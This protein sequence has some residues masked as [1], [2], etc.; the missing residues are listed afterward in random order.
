MG[1]SCDRSRA[2]ETPDHFN[3]FRCDREDF[4]CEGWEVSAAGDHEDDLF[5][6]SSGSSKWRCKHFQVGSLVISPEL[7]LKA[8]TAKCRTDEKVLSP[9]N[10]QESSIMKGPGK[11]QAE[12]SK[13]QSPGSCRM[14]FSSAMEDIEKDKRVRRLL[15]L[16]EELSDRYKLDRP[17]APGEKVNIFTEQR[18]GQQVVTESPSSVLCTIQNNKKINRESATGR[19]TADPIQDYK[20]AIGKLRDKHVFKSCSNDSENL[21]KTSFHGHIQSCI[22]QLS[23]PRPSRP[24]RLISCEDNGVFLKS[25][26]GTVKGLEGQHPRVQRGH[27]RKSFP[28]SPVITMNRLSKT[29]SDK[30]VWIQNSQERSKSATCDDN[31]GLV[32]IYPASPGKENAGNSQDIWGFPAFHPY[33]MKTQQSGPSSSR[34]QTRNE[35]R[36]LSAP[37]LH[38]SEGRRPTSVRSK[39]LGPIGSPVTVGLML[40]AIRNRL[41]PDH[42]TDR[43]TEA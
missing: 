14:K 33:P 31:A 32:R 37:E 30:Y 36:N 2:R 12:K 4:V 7:Y 41:K 29:D 43:L 18:E 21:A 9:N 26:N 13:T 1:R 6:C 22:S 38:S 19:N 20:D 40:S 35:K 28:A 10:I 17:N 25:A 11:V 24:V 5:I 39:D 15:S 8:P 3:L 34:G 42:V 16:A 23:N 27:H